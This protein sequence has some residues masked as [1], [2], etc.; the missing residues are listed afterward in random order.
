[1]DRVLLYTDDEG[2]HRW[3]ILAPNNRVIAAASEGFETAEGAKKNLLRCGHKLPE[4]LKTHGDA[5][6]D[7]EA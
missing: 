4:P 2:Q 6:L 1:M 5:A 7:D 3:K